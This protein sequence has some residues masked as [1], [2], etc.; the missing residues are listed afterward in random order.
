MEITILI[1]GMSNLSSNHCIKVQGVFAVLCGVWNR[2]HRCAVRMYQS[3]AGVIIQRRPLIGIL[4]DPTIRRFAICEL[5]VVVVDKMRSAS[6]FVALCFVFSQFFMGVFT[7]FL[8][9]PYRS[10]PTENLSPF[11]LLKQWLDIHG[12]DIR[13]IFQERIHHEY[14]CL[15]VYLVDPVAR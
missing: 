2:L 8:I 15:T 4:L 7:G 9:F 11:F 13:S 12:F 6:T 5:R 3:W 14:Q 10:Q 1:S